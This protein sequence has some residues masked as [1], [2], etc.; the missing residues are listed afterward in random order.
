MGLTPMKLSSLL[1]RIQDE[2][3]RTYPFQDLRIKS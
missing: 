3:V 2:F 1:P